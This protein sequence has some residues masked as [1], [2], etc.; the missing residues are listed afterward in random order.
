MELSGQLHALAALH[1]GKEP[2][3]THCIGGWVGPRASL[4]AVEKNLELP[5]I[6]PVASRYTD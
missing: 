5:G 2:S 6:E 3:G 1:P 4:D